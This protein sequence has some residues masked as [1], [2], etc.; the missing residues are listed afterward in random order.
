MSAHVVELVSHEES[1]SHLVAA[2]SHTLRTFQSDVVFVKVYLSAV[3]SCTETGCNTR[4]CVDVKSL[5]CVGVH[6]FR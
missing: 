5:L 4:I 3:P 2:V 6:Y 1:A